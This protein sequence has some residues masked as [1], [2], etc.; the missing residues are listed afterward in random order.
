MWDF[1][2]VVSLITVSA[3]SGSEQA[4]REDLAAMS[5]RVTVQAHPPNL[6]YP[7]IV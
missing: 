5:P 2:S 4:G 7:S 6:G 1:P 3:G